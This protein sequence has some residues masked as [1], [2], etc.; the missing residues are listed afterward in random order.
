VRAA[1]G[2]RLTVF[3]DNFDGLIDHYTHL[4]LNVDRLL[5]GDTYWFY[6]RRGHHTPNASDAVNFT[7]WLNSYHS[8]VNPSIQLNKVGPAMLAATDGGNWNCHNNSMRMRMAQLKADNISE[9]SIFRLEPNEPECN[10]GTS[11]QCAGPTSN[12][13]AGT[14]SGHHNQDGQR[15]CLCSMN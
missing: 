4:Q 5:D 10:D 14:Y 2:T 7:G 15:M 12:M 3:T 11:F 13:S 6:S 9:V 1:L 8:T